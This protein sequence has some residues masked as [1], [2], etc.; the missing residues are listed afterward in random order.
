MYT[1]SVAAMMLIV[2]CMCNIILSVCIIRIMYNTYCIIFDVGIQYVCVYVLYLM[3]NM[4]T[5]VRVFIQ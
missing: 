4:Y 2:L 5:F 1:D 3:C